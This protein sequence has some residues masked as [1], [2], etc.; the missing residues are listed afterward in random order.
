MLVFW[1]TG[2]IQEVVATGGST[3]YQART[4]DSVSYHLENN[5]IT[6]WTLHFFNL[7]SGGLKI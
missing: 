6:S 3:V 2:R 7:P 1:K 5:Q 4:Q